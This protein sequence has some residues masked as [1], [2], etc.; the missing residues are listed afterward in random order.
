MSTLYW[1]SASSTAWGTGANWSTTSAP[2]NGD[3]AIIDANG[4][5]AIA[6][7]DQ[8]AVALAALLIKSNFGANFGDLATALKI[9]SS[10]VRIGDLAGSGLAQTAKIRVN[11]DLSTTAATIDV[12]STPSIGPD[13]GLEPV[14]IVGV[15]SSNVLNVLS[16]RVGVATNKATDV[17]TFGTIN[18]VAGTVNVASGVTL[19]TFRQSSG[20]GSLY[21]A[22]TTVT[23]NGGQLDT[24]GAGAITTANI[25]GQAFLRATG[26]ITTLNVYGGGTAD[27]SASLIAR[28]VT[29]IN[30][31]KGA[32]LIGIDP[33]LFTVTNPI[34][35][36]G[37]APEDV[38][39]ITP[40]GRTVVIA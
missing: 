37:C 31:Y 29:T 35:L 23:I 1:S 4:A 27:F 32:T 26:T 6:G 33:S 28:T 16:G 10:L 24:Y 13:A 12:V 7:S 21:C 22:A 36:V 5:A 25:F 11:L 2:A 18:N 30:L 39:I 20:A 9:K 40:P 34:N 8:S 38:T 3:T 14:R 17:A 19:T 15:N